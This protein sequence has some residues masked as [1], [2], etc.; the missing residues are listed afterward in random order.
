MKHFKSDKEN[1]FPL[2]WNPTLLQSESD[3]INKGTGYGERL[4][5]ISL[6]GFSKENNHLSM[7]NT[8]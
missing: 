4:Q 8:R 2:E 5:I 7:I 3:L 1:A 6:K